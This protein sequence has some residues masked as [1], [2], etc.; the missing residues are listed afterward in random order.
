MWVG[1]VSNWLDSISYALVR[2]Q[3]PT[4]FQCL[5]A[6]VIVVAAVACC[7][8][9]AACVLC[10]QVNRQHLVRSTARFVDLLAHGLSDC[11]TAYACSMWAVGGTCHQSA[12]QHLMRAAARP[13][14]H[15][16]YPAL[17]SALLSLQLWAI[18]VSS[19]G[20]RNVATP[21]TSQPFDTHSCQTAS[22]RRGTAG[23]ASFACIVL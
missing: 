11:Y 13:D 17:S 14:A 4:C 3:T 2:T 22:G 8:A 6:S 16:A 1:D 10:Q 21:P 18:A 23:P 12:W 19:A 20:N 5:K 7:I 9:A 15:T